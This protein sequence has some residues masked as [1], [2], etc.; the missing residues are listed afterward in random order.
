MKNKET[1]LELAIKVL[2]E[3]IE[4]MSQN[5]ITNRMD[6]QTARYITTSWKIIK[7]KINAVKGK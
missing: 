2:D 5:H 7:E 6:K 3:K 1:T 4:D